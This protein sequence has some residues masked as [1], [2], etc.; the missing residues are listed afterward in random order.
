MGQVQDVKQEQELVNSIV[1]LEQVLVLE[2][3]MALDLVVCKT[4][5]LA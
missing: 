2:Q 5:S 1:V 4:I 3:G